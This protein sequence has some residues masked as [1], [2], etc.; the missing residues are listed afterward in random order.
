[1][2]FEIITPPS[3][4]VV[5]LDEVKAYLNIE[6]SDTSDEALL[7][8]LIAAAVDYCERYTGRVLLETGFRLTRNMINC[9]YRSDLAKNPLKEVTLAEYNDGDGFVTSTDNRVNSG[10]YPYVV[11]EDKCWGCDREV[12]FKVEF[13]A[14]YENVPPSLKQGILAHIA[15]MYENRGDC[16]CS[17]GSNVPGYVKTIYN[18]YKVISI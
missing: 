18:G 16:A 17:D 12:V 10:D 2:L 8:I 4:A 6:P 5:T 13:T 1:M 15:F 11:F 9:K 3:G 7:A 14:G